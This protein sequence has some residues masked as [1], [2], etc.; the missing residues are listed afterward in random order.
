MKKNGLL[1]LALMTV[2]LVCVCFVGC[3][4]NEPEVTEA[5][6]PV[7]DAYYNIHGATYNNNGVSS[8]PAEA[9]GTYKVLL[10][11]KGKNITMTVKAD[12]ELINK[13]DSM[14]ILGLEVDESN[15]V[16]G[17]KTVEEM[18][19][20]IIC[21]GYYVYLNGKAQLVVYKEELAG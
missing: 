17:V 11:R 3:Q 16:I 15:V 18:G 4:T 21:D 8:R 6:P 19:G 7:M 2:L 13:I 1:I 5:A 9:D 12:Q 20:K 14:R 10:S